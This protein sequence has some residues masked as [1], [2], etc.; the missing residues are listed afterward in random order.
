MMLQYFTESEL[1]T[2]RHHP[3]LQFVS[4]DDDEN[5]KNPLI[6]KDPNTRQAYQEVVARTMRNTKHPN[7]AIIDDKTR[8]AAA[9]PHT[10]Y[11]EMGTPITKELDGIPYEFLRIPGGTK[12]YKGMGYFYST[13]YKKPVWT[14]DKRMAAKWAKR[15]CGGIMVYKTTR[16]ID[17]FVLNK[18]NLHRLRN[19]NIPRNVKD[20]I[21][22]MYGLDPETG[23]N[24]NINK[25]VEQLIGRYAARKKNLYLQNEINGFPPVEPQKLLY[26]AYN[27]NASR[28]V[29]YYLIET[30][31][32][33][34][35]IFPTGFTP[36]LNEPL[37]EEITLSPNCIK[38]DKQDPLYWENWGLTLPS[39]E[40]FTL[41][42]FSQNHNFKIVDYYMDDTKVDKPA[43]PNNPNNIR[44]V[45]YNVHGCIS[46]NANHD[47][48]TTCKM[49]MDMLMNLDAD[50]IILQEV[51]HIMLDMLPLDHSIATQNGLF[52]S[53]PPEKQVFLAVIT[54]DL[55]PSRKILESRGF[56]WRNSI[57]LT[58]HGVN[59]V[60]THGPIGTR[61]FNVMG[62]V[63]PAKEFEKI[64]P[65][66]SQTRQRFMHVLMS[67]VFPNGRHTDIIAGDCNFIPTDPEYPFVDNLYKSDS[68]E[69]TNMHG[70]TV[71]Y[72]FYKPELLSDTRT[73]VLK[74]NESD[75]RPIMF[76]ATPDADI[77]LLEQSHQTLQPP[78]TSVTKM[79]AVGGAP[80]EAKKK[81]PAR[82][83][84]D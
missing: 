67:Y 58:Y 35:I 34:G 66:N 42:E 53:T 77:I 37:Y 4:S 76:D 82:C 3:N 11:M 70:V 83:Y 48:P 55:L 78:S 13:I 6:I 15:F 56:E 45:T 23:E 20:M 43:K 57:A 79:P 50:V 7:V 73:T 71:D 60:A 21:D 30:H 16:D 19:A 68:T 61:V 12:F 84:L 31:Q 46:P 47:I 1:K 72:V 51:P 14:G 27:F 52:K 36:F 62:E 32:L 81:H 59:I 10:I 41:N 64:Y 8:E 9:S 5:F 24:M 2:I 29:H 26:K 65:L 33:D 25:R 39:P 40:Q 38:I 69:P 49:N 63:I 80:V 44:I 17:L 74:W 28:D 54:K 18:A 22:T 75:H